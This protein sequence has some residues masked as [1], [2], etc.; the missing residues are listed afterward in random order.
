M[1]ALII[2]DEAVAAQA[3]QSLV[4]EVIT[5]VEILAVLQ[6]IDESAEW[7][8][9]H[10]MPDLVFMDIHLADGSSFAIFEEVKI[11][12]PIIFTTAYDEYALK[13]FEVNSIDYLLKP[14]CKSDLERAIGK[15]KSF[16]ARP[17]EN[18]DIIVRLLASVKQNTHSYKSYFLVAEKDKL[19]PLNTADIACVY[20]NTGMVKAITRGGKIFYLDQTLDELMQH[21]NPEKFFRANRQYII[22]RE[23]VKDMS[24]WFGSKLSVNLKVSTPDRILVS[25]AKVSEF[26]TWM[27][28]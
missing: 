19:I 8:K 18:S 20:I 27:A 7:F 23:A 15:Y 2:E 17:D 21:L 4:K 24:T 1:K 26:K 6:S 13:A 16:S 5:E 12:C 9:S 11:A 28:S 22:S 14:I 3:L 10:A 25:K